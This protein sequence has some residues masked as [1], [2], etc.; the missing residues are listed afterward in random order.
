MTLYH[1]A[2][3]LIWPRWTPLCAKTTRCIR[4]SV[5]VT[6][7]C[8]PEAARL[9][10]ID[11]LSESLV[12]RSQFRHAVPVIWSAMLLLNEGPG[13]GLCREGDSCQ[14]QIVGYR[15]W[16]LKPS[17]SF[18]LQIIDHSL[19]PCFT[20]G[21]LVGKRSTYCI[22]KASHWEKGKISTPCPI[23]KPVAIC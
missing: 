15:S 2:G 6:L 23:F 1:R 9:L 18:L 20:V 22:S 16:L 19:K 14:I 8:F 21:R 5:L 11:L 4:C 17:H 3:L 13:L 7:Q 10:F 12:Q